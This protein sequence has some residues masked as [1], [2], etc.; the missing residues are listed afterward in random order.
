VLPPD[1][2][3]PATAFLRQTLASQAAQALSQDIYGYFAESLVSGA[4][5]TLDQTAINAV[6]A[7][8]P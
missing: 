4:G 7:Q 2:A 5:L 6:H 8:F 1:D 3:D